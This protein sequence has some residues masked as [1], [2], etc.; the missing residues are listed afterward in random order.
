MPHCLMPKLARGQA[1]VFGS[2]S[3]LIE[4]STSSATGASTVAWL[5]SLLS[6]P[7]TAQRRLGDSTKT[8]H[9]LARLSLTG[10]RWLDQ[11]LT[12][13][14]DPG[15]SWLHSRGWLL[16]R[17][18]RVD[19]EWLFFTFQ[20]VEGLDSNSH[21]CCRSTPELQNCRTAD[22][23]LQVLVQAPGHVGRQLSRRFFGFLMSR[24]QRKSANNPA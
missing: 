9:W 21:C 14:C 18:T 17:G 2:P 22:L 13:E 11:H 5:L 4:L 7:S 8:T 20:I 24:P 16:P 3:M 1:G 6:L 23:L 10:V 12:P 19:L 15:P